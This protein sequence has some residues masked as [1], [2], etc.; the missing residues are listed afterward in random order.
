MMT[1]FFWFALFDVVLAPSS[2]VNINTA[3]FF[4]IDTGTWQAPAVCISSYLPNGHGAVFNM[5]I[6]RLSP[7]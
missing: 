7:S 2:K 1:L 3:S 5:L 4:S 6:I